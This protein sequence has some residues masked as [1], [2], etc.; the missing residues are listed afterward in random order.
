MIRLAYFVGVSESVQARYGADAN[1]KPL[2][3]RQTSGFSEFWW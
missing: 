3:A 2:A 1:K